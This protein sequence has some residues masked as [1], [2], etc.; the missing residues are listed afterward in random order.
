MK[1]PRSSRR[2]VAL[3][4][5]SA[6]AH[7]RGILR[8]IARY[9]RS[10]ANWSTSV[11]FRDA[12]VPSWLPRWRGDGMIARVETPQ[13]A[14]FLSRWK[15]PLLD[16]RG[17]FELGVPV[18]DTD[19]AAVAQV[20]L[21][22]FLERGFRQVGFAGFHRVDFSDRRLEHYRQCAATHRLAC[23]VYLAPTPT[24]TDA[25]VTYDQYALL[26]SAELRDWV[27][28]LPKPVGV[29][30]CTDIYAQQVL[31]ACRETACAVP[32][33]VAVL[34]VD[35][36]AVFCDL[37]TPPLSSVATD[38]EGAGYLAASY[39]DRMMAS[40]SPP[41]RRTLVR[42]RGVIC[43]RS[44]D[45]LAVE[46]PD[47]AFAVRF[48]REHAAQ[49]IRVEDVVRETALSRRTLERR[50]QDVLGRS[51]HDEIMRVRIRS[52]QQLLRDT[53][54]SLAAIARATGFESPE[55]LSVAF[56]RFTGQP[57]SQFREEVQAP[58]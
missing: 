50:F 21:E 42:P 1:R 57:P 30:A 46:D 40:G 34:G 2:A 44:T 3:L 47:L 14:R 54:L 5:P 17:H 10:L 52:V 11:H 28:Q 13:V 23:H 25:T 7:G 45:T 31:T 29:F 32:E 16:V 56:R 41:P 33:E 9:A 12:A 19:D 36:D 37:A 49:G 39:L 53:D 22:H 35:D 20:A 24:R 48:I 27:R 55:Y 58:R 26:Y 8:G 38:L 51:P 15:T 43:R 6:T 18:I 4:I